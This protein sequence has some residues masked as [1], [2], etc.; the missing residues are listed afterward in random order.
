MEKPIKSM[1]K[2]I[3]TL[4]WALTTLA[5]NRNIGVTSRCIIGEI[6]CGLIQG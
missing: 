2:P 1:E 5:E 6:S 4:K 3:K